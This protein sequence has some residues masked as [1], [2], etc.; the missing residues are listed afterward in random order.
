MGGGSMGHRGDS[1]KETRPPAV[2]G[3]FYP[4][5]PAELRSEVR[6]FV[7]AATGAKRRIGVVAPHAGYVYSGA[8]AGKVYAATEVPARVVVLAPNHTGMGASER[9]CWARGR[10]ALPG[11]GVP[12]DEALCERLIGAGAVDDDRGAHQREHALEVQLPF[13][14]DRNADVQVTP[15][16]LGHLNVNE[17]VALGE[18]LARLA[19][20]DALVV[21][22]SDM[23]H[24]L[25][26]ETTRVRDKIALEPLLRLDERGL[27][28][29]VVKEDISMCGFIPATVM[30]A[31]ARARGAKRATLVGYATSG[32]AFGDRRRVVGYAGVVVD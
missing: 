2:A 32:D 7:G 16:V 30:L 26:D 18:A 12:V 19:P 4:D 10:L 27:Y 23:N 5:D 1:D 24:Y 31:F 14:L 21:A 9:A 22:S 25:D 6:R 3:L 20:E 29:T 8:T 13:L 15:I 17:C 28:A 11:G